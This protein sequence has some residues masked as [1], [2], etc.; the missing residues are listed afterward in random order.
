MLL[1][2]PVIDVQ[3]S[4]H[5][6][7][8]THKHSHAL[9]LIISR[10]EDNLT[11][12]C[13][14]ASQLSD[15]HVILCRVQQQK[16]RPEEKTMSSRKLH[17]INQGAFQTDL[18]LE[19]EILSQC[20]SVNDV[21]MLYDRA[22]TNTLD[23][24]VPVKVSVRTWYNHDIHTARRIRR[25]FERKWRKIKLETDRQRYVDQRMVVNNLIDNAK[26]TYYKMNFRCLTPK[27]CLRGHN[28][29]LLA[30]RP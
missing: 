1:T 7:G 12:N 8:P 27:M 3:I 18:T 11:F 16:P 13:D 9:D 25:R 23:K 2:P 24:H 19:F 15:H 29:M 30:H 10:L 26:Q 28:W 22:I 4:Y 17:T 5:V 6:S 21:V 14:I 20:E